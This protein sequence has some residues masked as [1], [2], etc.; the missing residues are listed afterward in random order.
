M[1]TAFHSYLKGPVR[2]GPLQLSGKPFSLTTYIAATLTSQFYFLITLL[3]HI[4][5]ANLAMCNSGHVSVGSV[6][7]LFPAPLHIE[8]VDRQRSSVTTTES[9]LRNTKPQMV[10]SYWVPLET[11]IWPQRALFWVGITVHAAP[12]FQR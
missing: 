9:T 2:G 1:S 4:S 3:C 6:L 10:A 8:V 11:W 5:C 12:S 7:G